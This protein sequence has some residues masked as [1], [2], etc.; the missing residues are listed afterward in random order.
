MEATHPFVLCSTRWFSV[1][2]FWQVIYLI[3][4]WVP[5]RYTKPSV[6]F[7]RPEIGVNQTVSGR[8]LPRFWNGSCDLSWWKSSRIKSLGGLITKRLTAHQDENHS[9]FWILEPSKEWLVI[10]EH[11]TN[12]FILCLPPSVNMQ[13][14]TSWVVAILVATIGRL[15]N[16]IKRIKHIN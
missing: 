10:K 1:M 16:Y 6:F 7:R 2:A 5:E 9:G 11:V 15:L 3:N 13:T 4:H 8:F 14:L 12:I